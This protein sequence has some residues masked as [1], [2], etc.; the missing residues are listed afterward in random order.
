MWILLI[1][2]EST[3][4]LL[5]E[6]LNAEAEVHDADGSDKEYKAVDLVMGSLVPDNLQVSWNFILTTLIKYLFSNSIENFL[7]EALSDSMH[8]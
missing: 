2:S 6:I 1:R 4:S 5:K 8:S 7:L 3:G